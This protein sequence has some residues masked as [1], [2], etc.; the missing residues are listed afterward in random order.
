METVGSRSYS[1]SI[2]ITVEPFSA[3]EKSR[4]DD[5]GKQ[6]QNELE[7]VGTYQVSI[8][9]EKPEHLE[10]VKH[11]TEL[12]PEE[13]CITKGDIIEGPFKYKFQSTRYVYQYIDLETICTC[14]RLPIFAIRNVLQAEGKFRLTQ[15]CFN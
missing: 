13:V 1:T 10:V 12:F 7:N 3:I 4:Q 9:V 5:K 2:R 14:L 8:E 11:L 15:S 6:E